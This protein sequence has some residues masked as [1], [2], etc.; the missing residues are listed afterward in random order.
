[1]GFVPVPFYV[2]KPSFSTSR[3]LGVEVY[4]CEGGRAGAGAG[5]IYYL[6]LADCPSW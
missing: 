3:S 4:I 2:V 6:C 5:G 1:M